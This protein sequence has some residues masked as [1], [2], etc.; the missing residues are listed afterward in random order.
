[1]SFFCGT[2]N[3]YTAVFNTT[4]DLSSMNILQNL[5]LCVPQIAEFSFLAELFL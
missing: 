5:Y 2:Q 4:K 3:V 1:M